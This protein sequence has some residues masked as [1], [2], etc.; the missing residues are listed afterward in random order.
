MPHCI[1]TYTRDVEKDID[2]KSLLDVAFDA[3]ESAGLFE[4]ASIKARAMRYD[5]FKSGQSRDD[6]I[7][8]DLKILSGRT[9]EQKKALSDHLMNCISPHIGRTKSLTIDIIDMDKVSYGKLIAED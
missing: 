7:H 9:G 6:Y 1:V 5:I 3:V 2:I 4:R 8:I